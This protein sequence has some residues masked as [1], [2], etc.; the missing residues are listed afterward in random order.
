MWSEG[1][2]AKV[3]LALHVVGRR[4]D[5]YHLLESLVAFVDIGDELEA[6]AAAADRLLLSGPFASA[7]E[8]DRNNLVLRALTEFR[9]TFPGVLPAGFELS[10]RKNLPL[11]AG[12]GGGSADAA[13]ALRLFNAAAAEPVSATRL[14][15]LATGLGADLPV[16]L[17]SRPALMRGIGEQVTPLP[18]FPPLHAV[19]INP[20]LPSPTTEVF[21]RL[22]RRD[23]AP[24]PPLP[25]PL[26]RPAQLALWL[27]ETRNDLEAPA[28]ALV[29]VIGAMIDAVAQLSGCMAARMSGSGATVFGLFGSAALAHQAAHDLRR[30][31]PS[32]WVAAG[33]L[34]LPD[35]N[36]P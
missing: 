35:V 18:D 20:L 15:E 10:L 8:G 12:L 3:N 1:A 23:N 5:G 33:P 14:H 11:A 34:L 29:P 17:L 16:C 2:P 6:R 22:E 32:Y 4:D 36:S 13:A 27:R 9:A 24:L 25:S 19:L 7:L 31:F 28:R 26:T 30:G 21:R